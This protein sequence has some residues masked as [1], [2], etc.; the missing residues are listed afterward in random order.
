MSRVAKVERTTVDRRRARRRAPPVRVVASDQSARPHWR[1]DASGASSARSAA[2]DW[3][4]AFVESTSRSVVWEGTSVGHDVP[5]EFTAA[6]TAPSRKRTPRHGV[7]RPVAVEGP[8]ERVAPHV[9]G[10]DQGAGA[11]RDDRRHQIL[12]SRGVR[13]VAPRRVARRALA[14]PRSAPCRSA[15]TGCAG[16]PAPARTRRRARGTGSASRR[17][18]RAHRVAP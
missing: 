3:W 11:V 4:N 10:R 13:S 17:P 2:S 18:A 6:S 12:R 15:P 8:A 5:Q 9:P 7:C 16:A 14:T 1:H